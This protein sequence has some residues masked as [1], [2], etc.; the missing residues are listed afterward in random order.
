MPYCAVLDVINY[1]T[2]AENIDIVME[3]IEDIL[4]NLKYSTKNNSSSLYSA[5]VSDFNKGTCTFFAFDTMVLWNMESCFDLAQAAQFLM[6]QA[7]SYNPDIQLMLRGCLHDGDFHVFKDLNNVQ[8]IIGPG[9]LRAHTIADGAS[10]V[11]K[12][13][14]LLFKESL[15]DIEPVDNA[16]YINDLTRSAINYNGDY[17]G[18]ILWPVPII[19]NEN[20]YHQF[21]E[22]SIRKLIENQ[23]IAPTHKAHYSETALLMIR[24]VVEAYKDLDSAIGRVFSGVGVKEINALFKEKTGKENNE[25]ETIDEF[26]KYMD[27]CRAFVKSV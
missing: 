15:H 13:A 18:E 4:S 17:Y 27:I 22:I 23:N 24:S 26:L 19:L 8:Q 10:G 20:D 12:G 2:Y 25:I 14:R 6:Q 11:V 9:Y 21:L 7:W 16:I 3:V 1:K 5:Q